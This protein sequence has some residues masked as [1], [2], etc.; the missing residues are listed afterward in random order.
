MLAMIIFI[1]FEWYKWDDDWQKQNNT[2][3]IWLTWSNC[4]ENIDKLSS[5][6]LSVQ[7]DL[8]LKK[9]ISCDN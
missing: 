9:Q 2:L 5:L 3:L 1:N 4:V 7:I 8:F 6:K